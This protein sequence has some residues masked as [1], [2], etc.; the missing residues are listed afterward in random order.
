MCDVATDETDIAILLKEAAEKRCKL[1][2]RE[3]TAEEIPKGFAELQNYGWSVGHRLC[4]DTISDETPNVRVINE[5]LDRLE[6]APFCE[7]C[8]QYHEPEST[9]GCFG[10]YSGPGGFVGQY[11]DGGMPDLDPSSATYRGWEWED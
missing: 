7:F 10:M 2:R 6:D 8:T 9:L 5:A 11:G 3:L 1:G 4:D